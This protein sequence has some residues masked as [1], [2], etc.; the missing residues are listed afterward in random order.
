MRYERKRVNI[1]LFVETI[2]LCHF[3]VKVSVFLHEELQL[4]EDSL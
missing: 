4:I 2:L 1:G 3:S